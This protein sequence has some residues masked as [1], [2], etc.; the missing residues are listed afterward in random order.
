MKCNHSSQT[1]ASPT[2]PLWLST[3][4]LCACIRKCVSSTT[5][6]APVSS[7]TTSASSAPHHPDD[8]DGFKFF[9]FVIHNVRD[10][11]LHCMVSPWPVKVWGSL[12]T[13]GGAGSYQHHASS[14]PP[15]VCLACSQSRRPAPSIPRERSK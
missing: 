13:Q 6:P 5:L 15:S 14:P 7:S 10:C 8:G 9:R 11:R 2:P 3:L 12:G 1:A 4:S